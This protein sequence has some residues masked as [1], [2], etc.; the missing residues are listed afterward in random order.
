M[1]RVVVTLAD[2]QIG[3]GCLADS[4]REAL[5]VEKSARTES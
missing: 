2:G 5:R 4:V 1:P 3:F